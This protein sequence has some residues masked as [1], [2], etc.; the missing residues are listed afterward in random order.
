MNQLQRG[1]DHRAGGCDE[2]YRII[3][4]IPPSFWIVKRREQFHEILFFNPEYKTF[5]PFL[6]MSDLRTKTYAMNMRCMCQYV[7]A[8]IWIDNLEVC[9]DT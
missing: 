7:T 5:L 2:D 1:E 4:S 8:K 9:Y 6:E 3:N